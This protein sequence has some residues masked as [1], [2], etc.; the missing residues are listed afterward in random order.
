MLQSFWAEHHKDA[1][2]A[3]VIFIAGFWAWKKKTKQMLS[4]PLEAT[5]DKMNHVGDVSI[6]DAYFFFID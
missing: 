4:I 6:S 2:L 3:N 1:S 5:V